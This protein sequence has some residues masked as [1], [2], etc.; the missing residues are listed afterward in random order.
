MKFVNQRKYFHAMMIA[1]LCLFQVACEDS[2][3]AKVSS[4]TQSAQGPKGDAGAQGLTGA[5]GPQGPQGLMGPQGLVGPQGPAGSIQ[6]IGEIQALPDAFKTARLLAGEYK[7]WTNSSTKMLSLT[8]GVQMYSNNGAVGARL[9][10][11]NQSASDFKTIEFYVFKPEFAQGH[12]LLTTYQRATSRIFVPAG[13]TIR[14]IANTNNFN[15][16]QAVDIINESFYQ[17]L[18]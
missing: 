6:S 18:N 13:A 4:N 11:K 9:M 2:G 1:A 17:E 15:P 5:T 14:I 8:T 3:N 16:L 12:D 7:D 10:I